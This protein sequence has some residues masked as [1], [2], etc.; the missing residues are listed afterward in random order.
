MPVCP[1]FL[2]ALVALS[3]LAGPLAA[4][5]LVDETFADGDRRQSQPPASLA[6]F[7]SQVA[8]IPTI[9]PGN[10]TLRP[11]NPA[12]AMHLLAHLNEAGTPISLE[13]GQ[14]LELKVD[15]TPVRLGQ[16]TRHG[17]RVGL[18][19]RAGAALYAQDGQ[20]GDVGYLGYAVSIDPNPQAAPSLVAYRRVAGKKGRLM[21][22]NG[23][24]EKIGE[25]GSVQTLQE[26]QR[27]Q[28][29]LRLNRTRSDNLGVTITLEG[30]GLRRHTLTA[31][32]PSVTTEFDTI[33][34]SFFQSLAEVQI[35]RVLLTN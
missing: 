34:L 21:T 12:Q 28:M 15:F 2:R 4:A 20:N 22:N 29:T 17:L 27:Y 26:G 32:T 24:F 31:S 1:R 3:L 33:G 7:T 9:E 30:A 18:F 25:G 23:A 10:L 35:H 19:N 11:S 8:A 13:R 5:T 16:G 6:W 14:S